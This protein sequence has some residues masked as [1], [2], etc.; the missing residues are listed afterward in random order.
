MDKNVYLKRRRERIINNNG[1]KEETTDREEISADETRPSS[2]SLY[3]VSFS[4]QCE[5]LRG[6]AESVR[7]ENEDFFLLSLKRKICFSPLSKKT[8][9]FRQKTTHRARASSECDADLNDDDAHVM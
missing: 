9:N 5:A 3:V 8:K 4:S 1:R 7:L 2:F 6:G